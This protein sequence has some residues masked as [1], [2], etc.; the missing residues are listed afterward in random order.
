[1]CESP[2][3]ELPQQLKESRQDRYYTNKLQDETLYL[4]Q[5]AEEFKPETNPLVFGM[6]LSPRK[7]RWNL[8][9]FNSD[10]KAPRFSRASLESLQ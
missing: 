8:A 1:M 10:C 3:A 6:E 2:T 5:Q 9:V 7:N 4:E